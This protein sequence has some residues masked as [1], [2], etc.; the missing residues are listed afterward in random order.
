MNEND[1]PQPGYGLVPL[2]EK[3]ASAILRIFNEHVADGFAAYPEEHVTGDFIDGLLRSA[4]GYPALAAKTLDGEM[5]GFGFLRP[6]SPAA[7]F[8]QT[9]VTT[10]FLS[11]ERTG[12]GIGTAILRRMMEEARRMAIT[13]I[14]AHISSRNP[15]SI[16]FHRKHGFVECG[17]FPTIGRKWGEDFDVVWMVRVLEP[18][19]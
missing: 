14:L 19:A 11:A 7:A 6:Y 9:A 17:R 3:D 8:S 10:I 12:C 18:V 2:T 16:A 5:V 4:A 15:E 1:V 13:R